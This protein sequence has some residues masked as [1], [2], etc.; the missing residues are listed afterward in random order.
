[1]SKENL[2]SN[3]SIL[4]IKKFIDSNPNGLKKFR[5]F[6]KRGF[7]VIK[8]H[9]KT[10]LLVDNEKIVGYSHLDREGDDIWFG[11]MICDDCVGK[12]HGSFLIKETLS[13]FYGDVKLTVDK[14]N[15]PAINLYT[16]NNFKILEEHSDYFLMINKKS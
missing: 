1:M 11:I 10:L 6:N 14:D 13:E 3:P 5:Y 8:N 12:G 7:D 16:K 2:I 9:L 4:E 15:L